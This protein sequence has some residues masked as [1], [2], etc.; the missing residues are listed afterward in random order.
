MF[1][2]NQRIFILMLLVALSVI[3]NFHTISALDSL[4]VFKQNEPIRISQ[5]CQ[6]ANYI[7]IS[8][9]SYPN[10]TVA[11]SNIAMVSAGSGEFYYEF[12]NPSEIGRY[13]VR[14]ISDGCD[15]TFAYYFDVTSYGKE[16][17]TGAVITLFIILFLTILGISTYL[18]IY[19]FGH[20][21]SLDFDILDLAWNYGAYFVIIGMALFEKTYLGNADIQNFLDVVIRVGA[22]T[23]VVAPTI[24]FILTLTVGSY[25]A[26]R[27]KGV[28]Y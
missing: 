14:G 21:L 7:N 17:P 20:G 2:L 5:V 23:N 26:K 24:Y 1:K 18:V 25:M 9:I 27:V 10:S 13:D 28:D 15:K 12:I 8:S 22:V 4:G 6:D 3:A 16:K 11:V 19:S